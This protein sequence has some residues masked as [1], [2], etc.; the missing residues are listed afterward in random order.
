LYV[1]ELAISPDR[2]SAVG[3]VVAFLFLATLIAAFVGISLLVPNP[4]LDSLW[5]LN[6]AAEPVFRAMGGL[7]G[8]LLVALGVGTCAAGVGLLRRRK[9]AWWFAVVLFAVNGC[10]D[11]VGFFLTRDFLRSGSGVVVAVA[12]LWALASVRKWFGISAPYEA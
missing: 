8:A 2:P 6:P 5:R 10:G 3:L 1:G 4:W 9:W 12:F 11:V 7:A